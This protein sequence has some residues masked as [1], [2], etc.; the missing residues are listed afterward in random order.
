[1]PATSGGTCLRKKITRSHVAAVPSI[2]PSPH[3]VTPISSNN[4]IRI[5]R[6]RSVNREPAR[7]SG[8]FTGQPCRILGQVLL[9]LQTQ[10]VQR[11]RLGTALWAPTQP[12]QVAWVAEQPGNKPQNAFV[13]GTW[14][15]NHRR[16]RRSVQTAFTAAVFHLPFTPKVCV[17]RLVPVVQPFD[18]IL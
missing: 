5:S 16:C 13:R 1:M 6:D 9:M 2:L 11:A 8:P 17:T 12:H 7:L 10:L 3:R 15:R 14:H 4:F 18:T